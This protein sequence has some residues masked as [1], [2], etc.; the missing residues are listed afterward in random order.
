MKKTTTLLLFCAIFPMAHATIPEGPPDSLRTITVSVV[1]KKG[2]AVKNAVIYGLLASDTS[3]RIHSLQ[4]KVEL[5][6]NNNDT[7]YIVYSKVF[8]ALPLGDLDSARIILSGKK[9]FSGTTKD[10][11]INIGYDQIPEFLNVIPTNKLTPT[12]DLAASGYT[13][14]ASYLKGR[15]AGVN[16]VGSDDNYE[17]QIRGVNSFM[18]SSSALIIVDGQFFED[19]NTVNQ[20]VNIADIKSVEVL[21]DGSIYG[22]RG[23]NG[24]VIIT[25]KGGVN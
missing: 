7:L 20:M 5:E 11:M 1:N 18:L 3:H 10:E 21:K 6:C 22:S 25:T 19:F 9:L 12:T 4:G 24:A 16:V 23:A 15:I 17:I 8:K 14:L 13:D 2:K